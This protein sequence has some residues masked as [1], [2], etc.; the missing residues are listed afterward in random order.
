MK[1]RLSSILV[2]SSIGLLGACAASTAQEANAP[3]ADNDERR[4]WVSRHNMPRPHHMRIEKGHNLMDMDTNDDG[5]ISKAEFSTS[6]AEKFDEIDA[7]SDGYIEEQERD[8][9]VEAKV[10]MAMENFEFN[11]DF[12][13]SGFE[14]DMEEFEENME[15]FEE[16]MERMGERMGNSWGNHRGRRH[17]HDGDQR[18]IF[19]HED[20]DIE[21]R[22]DEQ[23]DMA[24]QRLDKN[25]D[26]KISRDEYPGPDR[27][28][29]NMDANNDGFV[30]RD[31]LK[32]RMR[33]TR[34]IGN[35]GQS[36]QEIII[37]IDED[38]EE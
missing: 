1:S 24:M 26:G 33:V 13:M 36:E 5:K 25:S 32:M 17:G 28:F 11:F 31:E 6:H 2:I 3:Q 34:S 15:E 29:D 38:D 10:E 30:E 18:R 35:W 20:E 37:T 12:D 21:V 16:N 22:I 27:R 8:D 7:N 9:F 19:V 23:K 4:V 14:E